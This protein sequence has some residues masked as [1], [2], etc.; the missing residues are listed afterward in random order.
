MTPIRK[1]TVSLALLTL[2]ASP[3][4]VSAQPKDKAGKKAAAAKKAPAKKAGKEA[5]KAGKEAK[6]AAKDEAKAD[7]A[8]A[9]DEAKADK[10]AA[11][12]EAKGAKPAAKDEVVHVHVH[13][14][15]ISDKK[16]ADG[17]HKML[18]PKMDSLIAARRETRDVRQKA[19][20]KALTD[21]YGVKVRRPAVHK[22]LRKIAWL[23]ARLERIREIYVLAEE[24]WLVKEVDKAAR[25]LAEVKAMRLKAVIGGKK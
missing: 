18:A 19:A 16:K 14:K 5:K 25:T 1:A 13:P 22:E 17:R 8:A 11:K 21:K 24:K 10:A 7:K 3:T 9:K 2:L 4:E 15:N 23:E 12:D 6:K 20:V